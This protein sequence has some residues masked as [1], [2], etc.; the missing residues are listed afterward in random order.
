[1]SVLERRAGLTGHE[2]PRRVLSALQPPVTLHFWSFAECAQALEAAGLQP[3]GYAHAP[4]FDSEV[5]GLT[6]H[7][8]F[9]ELERRA[10]SPSG[11]G[12]G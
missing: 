11:R 4:A 1:M 5:E 7:Y 8:G 10:P 2:A 9:W 12:P 3:R 6:L